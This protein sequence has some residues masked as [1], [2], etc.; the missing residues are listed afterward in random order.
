VVLNSMVDSLSL[1]YSFARACL[2]IPA[3]GCGGLDLG[4]RGVHEISTMVYVNA[5]F[6]V[7]VSHT[8]R[9]RVRRYKAGSQKYTHLR[10]NSA[11]LSSVRCRGSNLKCG[12]S[13]WTS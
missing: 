7:P 5:Q 11:A 6:G 2:V 3:R 13:K 9:C 12:A 10:P 8:W 4:E 1:R